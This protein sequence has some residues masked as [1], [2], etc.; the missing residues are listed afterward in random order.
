MSI[1]FEEII[2]YLKY[3]IFSLYCYN[4][5]IIFDFSIKINWSVGDDFIKL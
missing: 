4:K 3:W 5:M 2:I 1:F